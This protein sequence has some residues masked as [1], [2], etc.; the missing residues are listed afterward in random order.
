VARP[1]SE[2]R[3]PATDVTPA[4]HCDLHLTPSWLQSLGQL[5]DIS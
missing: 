5:A 1:L 2:I 4:D 3:E